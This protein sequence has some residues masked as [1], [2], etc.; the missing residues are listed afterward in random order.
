MLAVNP[1]VFH[2][3][4]P[5]IHDFLV[6]LGASGGACGAGETT[7]TGER[8][9]VVGKGGDVQRGVGPAWGRFFHGISMGFLWDFNGEW[10][11]SI[12]T[13]SGFH[14]SLLF[15][16]LGNFPHPYSFLLSTLCRTC[17][18]G[19]CGGFLFLYLSLYIY[20]CILYIYIYNNHTHITYICPVFR[21]LH[22][23]SVC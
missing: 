22:S 23:S 9:E 2:V 3:Q 4:I 8:W 5:E 12:A 10:T 14:V 17:F 15:V 20:T 11:R 6:H 18:M 7:V 21:V 1:N 16:L 19:F 13:F